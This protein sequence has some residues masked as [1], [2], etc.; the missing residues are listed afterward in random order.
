MG[1][2]TTFPPLGLKP[3]TV[4]VTEEKHLRWSG[5]TSSFGNR[6]NMVLSEMF[7]EYNIIDNNKNYLR[8][9]SHT[10]ILLK[11]FFQ[12]AFFGTYIAYMCSSLKQSNIEYFRFEELNY[13]WVHVG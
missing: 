2:R 13:K 1:F 11:Y 8:Q 9:H 3:D 5:D 4:E 6:I 12:N 10:D 7:I